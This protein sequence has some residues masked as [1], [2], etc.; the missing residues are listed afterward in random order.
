MGDLQSKKEKGT[1]GQHQLNLARI[2]LLTNSLRQFLI[3]G[4]LETYIQNFLIQDFQ[5][6]KVNKLVFSTH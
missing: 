4:E 2:I 5:D 1:V 6:C 3:H